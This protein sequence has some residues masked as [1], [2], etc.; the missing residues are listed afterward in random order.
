MPGF[1]AIT[2]QSVADMEPEE[3]FQATRGPEGTTVDLVVVAADDSNERTVT[4]RL[5]AILVPPT[6]TQ[7][8]GNVAYLRIEDFSSPDLADQVV[9]ALQSF[10]SE[11]AQGLILDLRGN[12]GG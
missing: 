1:S 8:M 6:E 4:V 5:A 3:S 2:G 7:L 9:T 12:P 10:S 11:S